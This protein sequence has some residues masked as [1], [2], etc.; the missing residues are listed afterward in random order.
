MYHLGQNEQ[1]GK[2]GKFS[3]YWLAALIDLGFFELSSKHIDVINIAP[4][5]EQSLGHIS[6]PRHKHDERGV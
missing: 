1:N 6:A 4:A 2:V 5:I 3:N